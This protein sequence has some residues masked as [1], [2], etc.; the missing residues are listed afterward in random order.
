MHPAYVHAFEVC[1]YL[2]TQDNAHTFTD[3]ELSAWDDAIDEWCS[4]HPDEA[5]P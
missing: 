2:V 4:Q 3:E 5:P 1:G